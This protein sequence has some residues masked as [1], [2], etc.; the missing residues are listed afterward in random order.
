MDL[1]GLDVPIKSE[2]GTDFYV[3]NIDIEMTLDSASLSFC[4]VF[5]KGTSH[6]KRFAPKLVPFV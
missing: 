1:Q 6:E 5:G 4:G 3:A 2:N